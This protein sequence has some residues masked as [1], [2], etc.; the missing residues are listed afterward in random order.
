MSVVTLATLIPRVQAVGKNSAAATVLWDAVSTHLGVGPRRERRASFHGNDSVVSQARKKH[1]EVLVSRDDLDLLQPTKSKGVDLGWPRRV[2]WAENVSTTPRSVAWPLGSMWSMGLRSS[3]VDPSRP[4]RRFSTSSDAETKLGKP[5]LVINVQTV[6]KQVEVPYELVPLLKD[7][8]KTAESDDEVALVK[9]ELYKKMN[10]GQS[11]DESTMFKLPRTSATSNIFLRG[12]EETDR[13]YMERYKALSSLMP[14][15][16]VV[17][18]VYFGEDDSKSVHCL[19]LG[20]QNLGPGDNF[21]RHLPGLLTEI[22]SDKT[23]EEIDAMRPKGDNIEFGR[24]AVAKP[25]RGTGMVQAFLGES[26]RTAM[27]NARTSQLVCVCADNVVRKLREDGFR[28]DEYTPRIDEALKANPQKEKEMYSVLMDK[29]KLGFQLEYLRNFHVEYLLTQKVR[30]VC[31][32]DPDLHKVF[33]RPDTEGAGKYTT[34]FPVVSGASSPYVHRGFN[35]F[36]SSSERSFDKGVDPT[37][38]NV[39][40]QIF[41]P[42]PDGFDPEVF[43]RLAHENPALLLGDLVGEDAKT[44]EEVRSQQVLQGIRAMFMFFSKLV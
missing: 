16:E 19:Y 22:F 30:I 25:F 18:R 41:K 44:L 38:L 20:F 35:G 28:V 7:A 43:L 34:R 11:P 27:F 24:L 33:Q 31:I 13:A 2:A 26:L 15:L 42:G 39:A 17:A 9:R 32:T 36:V 14:F 4:V 40:S 21:Y 23:K 3:V 1:A 10:R 6:P 12:R 37:L 5:R 29:E 8:L